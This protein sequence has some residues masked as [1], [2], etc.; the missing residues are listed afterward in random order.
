MVNDHRV[1]KFTADR[2][3][4]GKVVVLALPRGGEEPKVEWTIEQDDVQ[5]TGES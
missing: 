1:A 2:A 3:Y 5:V 4:S